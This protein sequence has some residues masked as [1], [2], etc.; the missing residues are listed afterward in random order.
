MKISRTVLATVLLFVLASVFP[1]GWS[2][3]QEKTVNIIEESLEDAFLGANPEKVRTDRGKGTGVTAMESRRD[4]RPSDI[5]RL[6]ILMDDTRI[7]VVRNAGALKKAGP[8][9]Y[10]VAVYRTG[11]AISPKPSRIAWE[12]ITGVVAAGEAPEVVVSSPGSIFDINGNSYILSET[13]EGIALGFV[14]NG[15]KSSILIGTTEGSFITADGYVCRVK[16]YRE[17]LK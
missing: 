7:K 11:A 15:R 12:K 10:V 1:A 6:G 3:A 5:E 13:E 17:G 8:G 9:P 4:T 16:R 2:L 14:T